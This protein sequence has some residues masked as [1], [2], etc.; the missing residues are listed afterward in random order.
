MAENPAKSE[1]ADVGQ[2]SIDAHTSDTG[3]TATPTEHTPTFEQ[4]LQSHPNWNTSNPASH[5]SSASPSPALPDAGSGMEVDSAVR[6][7]MG[8]PVN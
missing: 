5:G 6:R 1:P 7:S 3:S 8:N 4:D 2:A